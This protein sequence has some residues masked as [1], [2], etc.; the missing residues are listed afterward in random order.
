MFKT[1]DEAIE[2]FL[3]EMGD[4]DLYTRSH[5]ERVGGLME[6]FAKAIKLPAAHSRQMRLAGLFHDAGKLDMPRRIL[7]VISSG[8]SLSPDD[9]KTLEKHVEAESRL[10]GVGDLPA[11]VTLAI[12]HHHESWDGSG[13]PDRLAGTT[14]PP[15][16]RMLA[17]CD[18][19]DA[20]NEGK[21]G[22]ASSKPRRATSILRKLSGS[23]LDPELTEIFVK[24]V[25]RIN[26]PHT[27]VKAFFLR[28]MPS[29][30]RKKIS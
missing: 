23:R 21:P 26:Y 12:R 1:S 5:S 18:V 2:R 24:G 9:K 16:A 29:F 6:Q 22:R 7:D 14:I 27:S 15:S 10:A 4:K 25:V 19:F 13:F 17:I 30:I 20:V 28:F 11:T 3:T 8:G